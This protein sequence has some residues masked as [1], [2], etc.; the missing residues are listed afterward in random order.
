MNSIVYKIFTN[1]DSRVYIGSTINQSK[2]WKEHKRDL[3]KNL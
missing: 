3:L 1:I 2:R